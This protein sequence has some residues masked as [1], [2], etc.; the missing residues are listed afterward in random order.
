M[1]D[2]R[3][4]HHVSDRPAAST[5][6]PALPPWELDGDVLP[7]CAGDLSQ[8]AL[9]TKLAGLDD[10]EGASIPDDLPPVIDAH[11]HLFPDKLFS[12]VWRWFEQHGWPIRYPLHSPSVVKFLLDRGVEH[13]VAL[14]YA[15]KPGLAPSMN[16]YMAAL[17]TAHPRITGTATA[18]PGEPA[19]ADHLEE[20]FRAGLSGVKLHCHVQC[21][22]VDAPEMDPLYEVCV[23]FD[24]PMVIHAGREPKSPAY[25]CDP[26]QLCH[27]DRVE[28]VLKRHPR[29]RLVVPHLGADEYDAYGALLRRHDTLWLDTTMA[30]A[31]FLPGEVPWRLL[32]IRPDRLL[33]GSDFPNLPYAWDRELRRVRERGYP[34]RV[35]EALLGGNT[36]ELYGIRPAGAPPAG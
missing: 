7:V 29:L 20:A 19:A 6:D 3:H 4:Y 15:H 21:F 32:D 12:A 30:V 34:T 23:A 18:F 25:N 17:T 28:A 24:R 8:G 1:P 26:H 2:D 9:P 36:R 5:N 10:E 16:A 14:H 13:L 27:V 22:A 33:Y 35:L 11:V 31:G